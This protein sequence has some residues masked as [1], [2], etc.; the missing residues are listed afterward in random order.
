VRPEVVVDD[1][2][3][4]AVDR[5][6]AAAAKGGHLVLT[7]G[8][9][10]RVTYERLADMRHLDWSPVTVWFTDERCVPPDHE[11]SNYAMTK[12][13]LVDRIEG[14]GPA[15][16]RMEGERGPDQA[17]AAYH[18]KLRK[19]FGAGVPSLDLI[20]LGI[21]PDAHTCSLFPNHPA[22]EER[23]RLAVGVEN[24][25]MAPF[26]SRVT[27]TLPVVNA[28]REV[29]FLVSGQDKAEA[30]ARAFA[31]EPDPSAPA[32]L[33]RPDAGTMTLIADPAAVS[34]LEGSG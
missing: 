31:G 29:I 13:A 28:A 11:L 27:L 14:D 34:L 26:V 15:V 16:N 12:A 33:V 2:A 23:E 21:G 1:P 22:L 3:D 18:E 20:L 4:V 17:A 5:L 25:G 32:S 10:P 8:S 6:A 19:A 30:V 9:T 7:G 24:P